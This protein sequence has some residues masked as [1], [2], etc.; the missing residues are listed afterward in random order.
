[1]K[2]GVGVQKQLPKRRVPRPPLQAP[3]CRCLA[4]PGHPGRGGR[5][6]CTGGISQPGPHLPPHPK[7]CCKGSSSYTLRA[8]RRT[9]R[10]RSPQR[11]NDTGSSWGLWPCT[12][13]DGAER[14]VQ[15]SQT[16]PW[17]KDRRGGRS[18]A[19]QVHRAP[20][21]LEGANSWWPRRHSQQKVDLRRILQD[22]H[23]SDTQVSINA[24]LVGAKLQLLKPTPEKS[25]FV[26]R[27]LIHS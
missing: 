2:R 15:P 4:R 11:L 3:S 16:R 25:S 23:R 26:L 5:P 6:T 21:K 9:G 14:N 17:V 20:P 19:E 18:R 7:L 1:M 13:R 27:P 22:S 10:P 8:C 24:H 12:A